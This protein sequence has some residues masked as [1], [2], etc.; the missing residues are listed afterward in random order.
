[1]FSEDGGQEQANRLGASSPEQRASPF[2]RHA[3]ELTAVTVVVRNKCN[4]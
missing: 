3:P 2:P 1:M 4:L